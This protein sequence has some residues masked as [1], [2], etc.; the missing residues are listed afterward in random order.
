[1]AGVQQAR[2]LAY[3]C[4]EDPSSS[5]CVAIK[6]GI[7]NEY[8]RS[9]TCDGFMNMQGEACSSD[10][11]DQC[12][13]DPTTLAVPGNDTC[14]QGAVSRY[15]VE[16]QDAADVQ[17]ICE[18]AELPGAETLSIMNTGVDR[19]MRGY[20]SLLAENLPNGHYCDGVARPM[21]TSPCSPTQSYPTRPRQPSN[22]PQP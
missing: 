12:L 13:L 7:L 18:Y 3:P 16:V 17:A 2:P 14:G 22:S 15:Y 20:A 4:F 19:S 5:E 9:D 11:S 10:P 21:P 8:V 6:N 1:M